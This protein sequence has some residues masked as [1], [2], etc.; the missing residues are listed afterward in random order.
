MKGIAALAAGAIVVACGSANGND[1]APP[2]DGTPV[3]LLNYVTTAPEHW[4]S[5][6]PSSTMRLVEYTVPVGDV[7]AEA[8]EV[9]VYFFGPGQGGSVEANAER[10]KAQFFDQAGNH[11]EP[12]VDRLS[13]TAFPTSVVELRGSY[14]RGIG[15]GGDTPGEAKPGQ[16]L[17]AVVVETPTGNLYAQ[18]YGPEAGVLDQKDA[19]LA[20]IRGIRGHP[21]P[22]PT[23]SG[24]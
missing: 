23:A 20:F 11:P 1:G 12:A 2:A 8:V 18:M 19:F 17:I 14:A 16:A 22:N 7:A 21:G 13:D 9:I 6:Q 4:Q 5:R 24:R 3:A 10:W 15:M